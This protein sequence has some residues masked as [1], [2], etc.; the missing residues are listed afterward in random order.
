MQ[1]QGI[2]D[3]ISAASLFHTFNIDREKVLANISN[4]KKIL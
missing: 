1:K 4:L 2:I 3:Y